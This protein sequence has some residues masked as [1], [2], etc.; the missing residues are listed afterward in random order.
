MKRNYRIIENHEYLKNNRAYGVGKSHLISFDLA[1]YYGFNSILTEE[2]E[3]E[4]NHFIKIIKP[5]AIIRISE[6]NKAVEKKIVE[7]LN[8]LLAS[9]S[10]YLVEE[11]YMDKYN[12]YFV[13]ADKFNS[14]KAAVK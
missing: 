9:S 6:W 8:E 10:L 5:G 2:R 11:M 7:T 3:I 1:I 13:V 14:T 4:I 12:S